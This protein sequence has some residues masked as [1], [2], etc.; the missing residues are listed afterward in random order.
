MVRGIRLDKMSGDSSDSPNRAI[1]DVEAEARRNEEFR[2]RRIEDAFVA[3]T[4]ERQ[5]GRDRTFQDFS[6]HNPPTYDGIADP[7]KLESW[8]RQMK[9][10]F[11]VVGVPE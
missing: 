6:S 9:K 3:L 5:I 10:L 11:A 2:L 4:A 7:I 8:E 1:D